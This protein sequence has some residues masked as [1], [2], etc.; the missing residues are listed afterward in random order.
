ML[1]V[2]WMMRKKVFS[3]IKYFLTHPIVT[4]LTFVRLYYV[5]HS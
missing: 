4:K 2:R 1:T 5:K 3:I